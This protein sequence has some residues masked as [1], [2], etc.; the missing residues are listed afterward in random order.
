MTTTPKR[1][2]KPAAIRSEEAAPYSI[3]VTAMTDDQILARAQEI[4][5]ARMRNPDVF[6]NPHQTRSY[7]I[8]MLRPLQHE[9][10]GALFVDSQNR[11]VAPPTTLA[12]GTIDGASVYPREVVKSALKANAAAVIFYHN[13][14]SGV[15]EPSAADRQSTRRL[16]DA[17]SLVDIRVLDHFVCGAASSVSFAERGLL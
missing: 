9:I 4:A 14:P 10:F 7:L 2:R 3:A 17:L 12:T 13:H 11:L 15:P 8:A 1:T 6:I 16:V 5:E